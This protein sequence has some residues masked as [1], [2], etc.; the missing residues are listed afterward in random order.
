M[1][2]VTDRKYNKI[3]QLH[4]GSIGELIAYEDMFEQ[5]LDTGIGIY[6]FKVDKTHDSIANVVAGCYLFVPDDEIT[7][8]FEI[9]R[10]EEDH[11]TKIII[12]EDAGLDLL[13][14]TLPPFKS[15]QSQKLEYYVSKFA[16]DSGWEIGINEVTETTR[17]LEFEQFETTTKRLRTL[18]KE[19]DA[20]LVYSVEMLR[21]KPHRKLI[22]FY[23]KYNSDKIIRLEYGTNV[24]KI[25]KTTNIENLATAIRSVGA[26]GITLVDYQYNDGRYRLGSDG[27]LYDTIENERWKRNNAI[28]G[29]YIVAN[30]ESQAKTKERLLEETLKQLKKRA[31]PEV[32]YEVELDLV[33]SNV[34]IGQMAEV[35]DREFKPLIAIS[36]RVTSIKRSFSNKK[37]GS[38]KISNITSTEVLMNEK[39]Q[40]LS[41]LVQERV[42]DSTAVP[43]VLDLKS[44]SGAVFQNGNIQTKLISTVSK[45]GTDM[46]N[47]FNFRWIRKS[48]Y[49]TSDNE[50]NKLHENATREITITSNDVDREATFIC[51]ALENS[52][53]IA[54]NSIVIKD[55]IVNKSIGSTPPSNPSAGDL[56]TDTSTPGKEIPKIY[57]NGEWKAVLNKDDKELERL[58]KEFEERNREH[59][60]Q[61]AQV[62]EIINKNEVNNDTLRD[63]TGK[64]SNMEDT[65]NRIMA[66]ADEIKGLGQRTKAVE[67]NL[68]QSQLLINTLASN[69]SLSEDGFLLGKNGSKLQIKTTNERMEF[70]DSGRV[71]AF[72]SGQTMNIV[73]ATFWNSVTIANHIFERFNDEFTTISYVGGALIG[74]NI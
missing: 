54:R 57:S 13:G 32:T 23:K 10:I 61:F 7:R 25:K 29:G 53:V 35:S 37:I 36:A 30:Y 31:Y 56:W 67:L 24:T 21:D 6:E 27:V 14:E 72:V 8:C 63:L 49:G 20:E 42:F 39:L 73:S 3:C 16:F 48:K 70:I 2:T 17:K 64:F 9:T 40:R 71:V 34:L 68:E 52:N 44:T 66:T 15:E 55:F 38:V 59:A 1:I 65:Y 69:F 26:E 74:K 18:A 5:D 62:M 58:Q 19:F 47:R 50:W 33:G 41:Q 28:S 45:L 46:T 4:F 51:E 60:N 22:N 43:F 11:D 12:A